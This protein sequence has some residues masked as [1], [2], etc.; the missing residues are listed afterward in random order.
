MISQLRGVLIEKSSTDAVIECAGVGYQVFISVVTYEQLPAE[1]KDV[2]LFTLLIPREDSLNLYGFASVAER[3]AFV[4][5][6]SISG[7]G[8]K[9]ALGIL[10]ALSLAELRDNIIS[11]NVLALQ[12]L[13][14]VG[15]KTA[16]RIL[17]ELRDQIGKLAIVGAS[18]PT[19]EP[20]NSLV[21]QEAL[22]ALIA[23]G[24]S[25]VVAEKV[26]KQALNEAPDATAEQLIRKGLKYAVQ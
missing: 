15:K 9:I 13:P 19:S 8:P 10:S 22:A 25:K 23:L 24:Y 12:K 3:K 6:T 21:K 14:G 5:L 18:L 20:K 7:I 17:V 4:L 2:T 26:I 16:E 1:G 11:G